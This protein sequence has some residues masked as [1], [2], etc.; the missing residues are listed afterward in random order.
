MP[1]LQVRVLGVLLLL[2]QLLL[3]MLMMMVKMTMMVVKVI[4]L[5][6][7]IAH[8]QHDPAVVGSCEREDSTN[9]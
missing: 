5:I 4:M 9:R 1:W 8:T 6:L 7:R 3:L 2:P